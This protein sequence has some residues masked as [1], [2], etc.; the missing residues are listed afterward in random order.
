M[1]KVLSVLLV[2]ILVLTTALM[3]VACQDKKEMIGFDI[4]LAKAVG[5]KLD[6][7]VEF[8]EIEWSMKE[9][10][11]S[12]KNIDCI[13]NGFT[14][15]D[16]RKETFSFSAPYMKNT[17][18]AVV[19][20]EDKDTFKLTKDAK[21]TAEEGSAG[22]SYLKDFGCTNI[23]SAQSQRDT[24]MELM[25]KS[26]DVS[27]MDKVMAGYYVTKPGSTYSKKLAIVDLD[28][29]SDEDYAIGF[30]KADKYLTYVVDKALYEL[31]ED[32]TIATIAKKYG[33]EEALAK[34]E[35]PKAVAE[36][37]SLKALNGKMVIGYTIFAP[38]AYYED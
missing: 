35:E 7:K 8:K 1:K 3:C 14:V 11:L 4:E 6:L 22:E 27:V 18:V 19:R 23:L 9:T 21:V 12:A 17:Q 31:Q 10:E 33:L 16:E 32:G 34:F 29:A 2:V 38:I 36:D 20:I 28:N 24:F 30:R 26:V 37:A 15:T 25:S 13:W 5:E